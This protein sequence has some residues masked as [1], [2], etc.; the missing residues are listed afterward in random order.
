MGVTYRNLCSGCTCV[1]LAAGGV[2]AFG[3]PV[4]G[5]RMPTATPETRPTLFK[6]ADRCPISAGWPSRC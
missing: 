3:L 4:V 2:A 1:A 6:I 5:S